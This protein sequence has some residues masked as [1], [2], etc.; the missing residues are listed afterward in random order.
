M[1]MFFDGFDIHLAASVLGAT[2][3]SGFSTLPENA[4]SVSFTFVGMMLGSAA[5]GSL[6]DPLGRR[7][8]YRAN[9][10]VFGVASIL[11]AFAPN[12]AVLIALR[13]VMGV[14]LGAENVVGYSI[15]TEFVPPAPTTSP[16]SMSATA[17]R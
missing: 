2:F 9:L 11:A 4:V 8:T 3:R 14:G 16:Q 17:W 12:M 15:M 13:F 7:F 10:A 5:T 6:G 1:G